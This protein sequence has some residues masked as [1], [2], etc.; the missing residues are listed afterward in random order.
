[1]LSIV[2]SNAGIDAHAAGDGIEA[3]SRAAEIH[4]DLVLL[5]SVM[6]DL[7]GMRALPDI[8]R[9]SPESIVVLYTGDLLLGRRLTGHPAGPDAYIPKLVAPE[10]LVDELR[11]IWDRRR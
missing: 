7:G 6:P 2:L 8:R 9:V 3:V 1:M 10:A 11:R 5:D 4:P